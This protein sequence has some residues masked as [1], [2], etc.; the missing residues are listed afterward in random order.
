MLFCGEPLESALSRRLEGTVIAARAETIGSEPVVVEAFLR[1]FTKAHHYYL[2]NP[3]A[4]ITAM[5]KVVPDVGKDLDRSITVGAVRRAKS[6]LPQEAG[7]CIAGRRSAVGRLC[8]R[9]CWRRIT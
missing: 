3:R 8:R 2:S 5:S 7:G 1:A 9:S 4:G 6:I